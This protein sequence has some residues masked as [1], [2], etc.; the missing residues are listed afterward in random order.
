MQ[1]DLKVRTSEGVFYNVAYREKLLRPH[2]NVTVDC[3]YIY[4]RNL[5]FAGID[6]FQLGEEIFL[7]QSYAG[8]GHRHN[9]FKPPYPREFTDVVNVNERDNGFFV[10]LAVPL[11]C[12]V[13]LNIENSED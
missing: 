12:I 3:D 1:F 9:S 10:D 8:I 7:P 4:L 5:S 13:S 11:K 6:V 2:M